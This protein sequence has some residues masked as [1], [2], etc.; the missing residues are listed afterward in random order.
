MAKNCRFSGQAQRLC[1][2]APIKECYQ[3]EEPISKIVRGAKYFN[4]L[5]AP[6]LYNS[7]T[8]VGADNTVLKKIK[9]VLHVICSTI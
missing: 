1:S 4:I 6:F 2:V 3:I 5:P 8:L 9:K 7:I